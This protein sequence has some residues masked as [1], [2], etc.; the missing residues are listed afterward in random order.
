MKQSTLEV[1]RAKDLSAPRILFI[2][3][4]HILSYPDEGSQR[5]YA[6]FDVVLETRRVRKKLIKGL[7]LWVHS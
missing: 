4:T 1:G 6:M 5:S 3:D 7:N 2:T